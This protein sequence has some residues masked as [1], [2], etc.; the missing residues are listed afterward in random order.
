M[1]D[2]AV[3]WVRR[4]MPDP[5]VY[6]AGLTALTFAL[7]LLAGPASPSPESLPLLLVDA[8]FRGLFRILEFAMQMALVL[9]AGHALASAPPVRRLLSAIAALPK[10]PSHAAALLVLVSMAASFLNWGFGLV[11]AALLAREV[12]RRVR[13]LDFPL[14]VAAAYSGFVVFASGFSSS[15]ALVSATPGSAMNF[16]EKATGRTAPFAETIFTA[17]NLAP[18]AFL[19][20][21]VPLLFAALRP[22][23]VR[24][25]AAAPE[26][27]Q[28]KPAAEATPAAR[29]ERHPA[30]VL[31]P[32]GLG[33]AWFVQAAAR[34]TLRPDVN[35]VIAAFLFAG[36]LLHGRP[37][38]Y[39]E[40]WSDGARAVGPILLQYP[41]YGGILGLLTSSALV[42]R[43]SHA[44]AA[45]STHRTFPLLAFL[46]SNV[47]S[48]FVPSAGGHWAIQG[49]IMLPAAA[50][51]HVS[52]AVTAMA[53]AMGEETAN[54][55]QPFWALPI[56]AIAGLSARDIMGY[57]LATF[58]LGLLA[59]GASL[60]LLG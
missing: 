54:M 39:L 28:P 7:A 24:E 46:S 1:T 44:A 22:A 56:L 47:V 53:V 9:L 17:Y 27:S 11:T 32:V 18:V 35:V 50:A 59:Y 30:F 26:P 57:C 36:L 4:W 5:F 48:L 45:L 14:A 8:W 29:L 40:A 12:G 33:A 34:G 6:A 55:V 10:R 38:R 60:A 31:V 41:L 52:P 19:A 51:L 58:G 21:A 15:I 13:G 49:P 37:T 16:I 43:L 20:L 2:L 25:L 3:R 23:E 42:G